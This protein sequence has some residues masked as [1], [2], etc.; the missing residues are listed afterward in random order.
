MAALAE[1]TTLSGRLASLTEQ[2]AW[3]AVDAVGL[4]ELVGDAVRAS[5]LTQSVVTV[6]A[7]VLHRSGALASEGYVSTTRWLENEAG[8]SRADAVAILAR[9]TS[10]ASD[11]PLTRAALLAGEITGAKAFSGKG[12]GSK[13]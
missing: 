2:G 5:D 7:G 13:K 10:L 1:L 9:A 6:G 4:S 12:K 3:S 11:Y 8:A